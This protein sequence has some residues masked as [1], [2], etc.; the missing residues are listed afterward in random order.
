MRL[1]RLSA[2]S[3]TLSLPAVAATA[4][5]AQEAI[6]PRAISLFL[7]PEAKITSMILKPFGLRFL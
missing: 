2:I 6:G 7:L 3:L 4:V 5:H 1:C